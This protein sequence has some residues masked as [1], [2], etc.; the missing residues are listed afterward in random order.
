ML[1]ERSFAGQDR[2]IFFLLSSDGRGWFDL[3]FGMERLLDH[4]AARLRSVILYFATI[5]QCARRKP[6]HIALL[7][8]ALLADGETFV[9]QLEP[10]N[11]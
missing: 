11:K 2:P 3:G 6:S 10:G 9:R 7:S 1:L 4:A 8:R 5:F